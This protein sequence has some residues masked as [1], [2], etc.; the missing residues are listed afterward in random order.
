MKK[1]SAAATQKIEKVEG[2]KL[3]IGLDLED[4]SS[5]YCVLDEGIEASET[6]SG[7]K[8]P[9]MAEVGQSIL[10]EHHIGIVRLMQAKDLR[11]LQGCYL[12][13]ATCN[14]AQPRLPR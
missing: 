7:R 14:A 11:G 2:R 13:Q 8:P 5:S 3:T 4:R 12:W 9:L 10:R 6:E 1:I